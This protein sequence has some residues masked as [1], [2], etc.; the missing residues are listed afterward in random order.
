MGRVEL[1]GVNQKEEF[2]RRV[3]EAVGSNFHA[4][5]RKCCDFCGSQIKLVGYMVDLGLSN[6]FVNV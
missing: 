6:L 2:A 1:R 4:S 3:K 5:L